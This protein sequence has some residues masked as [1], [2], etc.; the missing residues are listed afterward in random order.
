MLLRKA[1]ELAAMNSPARW[2]STS[3]RTTPRPSPSCARLPQ[4][5][6]EGVT[7]TIT[8]GDISKHL[9]VLLEAVKGIPVFVYLDPCGLPIPLDEV[10]TIFDRPSG[11][12]LRDRGTDQPDG[13]PAPIRRHAVQRQAQ[14]RLAEADR[15]GVRR[16]LVAGRVAGEVP[17]QERVRGPEDGGRAGRGGGTPRNCVNAPAAPARGSSTSNRAPI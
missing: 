12:G 7:Y 6:G 11:P 15:R 5:E 10:A 9:P 2:N 3:W 14:S 13:W 4:A 17:E 1:K 16:E 8:D